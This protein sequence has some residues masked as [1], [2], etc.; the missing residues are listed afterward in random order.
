MKMVGFRLQTIGIE[1]GGQL[2]NE[3]VDYITSELVWHWVH[4]IIDCRYNLAE[5]IYMTIDRSV[6]ADNAERVQ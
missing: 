1:I 3:E 2:F 6:G 4:D 5:N